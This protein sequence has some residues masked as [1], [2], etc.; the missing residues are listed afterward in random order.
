MRSISPTKNPLDLG[1]LENDAVRR[2]WVGIAAAPAASG[3]AKTVQHHCGV[4]RIAIIAS[5]YAEA[6]AMPCRHKF[7]T[8]M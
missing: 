1:N 6:I 3:E 8:Q 2:P 7:A 5:E 4:V